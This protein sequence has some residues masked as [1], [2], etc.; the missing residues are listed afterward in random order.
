MARKGWNKCKSAGFCVFFVGA[1]RRKLG[2]KQINAYL[3][4]LNCASMKKSVILLLAAM[5]A[6]VACSDYENVLKSTDYNV[7]YEAAKQYYFDGHYGQ[8]SSL[9]MDLIAGAK[10]TERAEEALYLLGMSSFKDKAYDAAAGYFKKYYQTYPKGVYALQARYMCGLSRYE[11]TPEPRLDQTDTYTAITEFKELADA[12]PKTKYTK[13][14]MKRIFE[15]QDKL[16]D[17]EYAAAKLYYDLGTYFGNCTNGGSNYQACIVTS[18]NAINDYPYSPRKEDFAI[19]ILRSK[20]DLAK[21][22]VESRKT[23]RYQA[24]IDEYYGFVNE[25]PESKFIPKA[26]ALWREARAQLG[27]PQQEQTAPA[28]STHTGSE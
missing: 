20:F 27:L 16:I 9:F 17:K 2:G 14:A 28:D 4:D 8:A 10:G 21:Q 1:R 5:F 18:Q 24:A 11:N 26:H 13:E 6:F 3:C 19:L 22:S 25:F 12:Y 7:R 15:L 23:E